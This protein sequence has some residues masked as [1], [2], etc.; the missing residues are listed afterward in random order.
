MEPL[1]SRSFDWGSQEESAEAIRDIK[2]KSAWEETRRRY[3]NRLTLLFTVRCPHKKTQQDVEE[4]LTHFSKP[5]SGGWEE[6]MR[7]ATGDSAPNRMKQCDVR[8]GDAN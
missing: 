8:F 3:G 5:D 6:M 1:E 7:Q 4:A 2:N